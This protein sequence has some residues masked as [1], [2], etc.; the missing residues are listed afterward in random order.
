MDYT[1]ISPF[2]KLLYADGI[3]FLDYSGMA[4]C[5]DTAFFSDKEHLNIRGADIFTD[6][7]ARDLILLGLK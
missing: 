3:P 5:R 2:C 6:S 1:D 4:L 7:L